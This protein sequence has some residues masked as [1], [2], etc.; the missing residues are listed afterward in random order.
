[1]IRKGVEHCGGSVWRCTKCGAF[2]KADCPCC[3][4]PPC[5]CQKDQKGG[6]R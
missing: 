5:N 3:E 1:M 4:P 6:S 2:I